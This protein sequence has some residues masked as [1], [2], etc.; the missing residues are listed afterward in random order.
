MFWNA[1]Y[2][3]FTFLSEPSTLRN[4]T[5]K[6]SKLAE[7]EK[8]RAKSAEELRALMDEVRSL[9]RVAVRNRVL[10][11]EI[12]EMAESVEKLEVENAELVDKNDRLKA[13]LKEARN[14]AAKQKKRAE[15]L[16][17]RVEDEE[18]SDE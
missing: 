18:S 9:R 13:L 5:R 2:V 17:K 6:L 4:K 15:K 1:F 7:S 14:D 12:D 11:K 3:F 8:K 10:L 16:K